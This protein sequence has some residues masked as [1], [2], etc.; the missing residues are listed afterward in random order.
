MIVG[1]RGGRGLWGGLAVKGW[2]GTTGCR[3]QRRGSMIV[4]KR[5]HYGA[6]AKLHPLRRF[7]G[8]YRISN[9]VKFSFLSLFSIFDGFS[10]EILA[11]VRLI[12]SRIFRFRNFQFASLSSAWVSFAEVSTSWSRS[13]HSAGELHAW[14]H[15][16]RCMYAARVYIHVYARYTPWHWRIYGR[17]YCC[18]CIF[19]FLFHMQQKY[20]CRIIL[21]HKANKISPSNQFY[22]SLWKKPGNPNQ[23]WTYPKVKEILNNSFFVFILQFF[24]PGNTFSPDF[25]S[26]KKK[27][28]DFLPPSLSK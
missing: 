11:V 24:V 19:R 12:L 13:W 22:Y 1:Q 14:L 20:T 18:T 21:A 2:G 9:S 26:R 6:C 27:I 4:T 25:I 3:M 23:H 16:G 7:A 5:R 10:L 17:K 28:D 15:Y 8:F